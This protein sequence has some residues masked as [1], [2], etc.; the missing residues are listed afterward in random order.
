MKFKKNLLALTLIFSILLTVPNWVISQDEDEK[1]DEKKKDPYSIT[2]EVFVFCAKEFLPQSPQRRH[3]ELK[4][5]IQ[6]K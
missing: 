3:K 4:E 6:I 2:S 1:K 5:L